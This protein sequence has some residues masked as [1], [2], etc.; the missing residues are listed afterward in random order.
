MPVDL[1]AI[2][3]LEELAELKN[4][5]TSPGIEPTTFLLVA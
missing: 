5:M 4:S 3:Q 2:V 1:R